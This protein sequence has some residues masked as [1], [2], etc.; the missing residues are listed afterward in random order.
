ML[1]SGYLKEIFDDYGVE[2]IVGNRDLI[3]IVT[4]LSGRICGKRGAKRIVQ[5]I[6]EESSIG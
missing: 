1:G 6:K 3:A 2:L 4:S 5:T